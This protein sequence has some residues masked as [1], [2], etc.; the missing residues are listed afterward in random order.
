MDVCL[1]SDAVDCDL[2]IRI[3]DGPLQMVNLAAILVASMDGDSDPALT[4][5]G[6][7]REL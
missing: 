2:S 5:K 6:V 4:V 1:R 7:Q 3:L